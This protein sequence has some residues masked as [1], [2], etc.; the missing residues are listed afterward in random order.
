MDVPVSVAESTEDIRKLI[1]AYRNEVD[2]FLIDTIGYSPNDFE[3]IGKMRKI[4][5]VSGIS[6][7]VYLAFTASTKASDIRDIIQHYELFDFNSVI[8]TKFDETSCVGNVISILQEKNKPVSFITTGQKVPRDIEKASVVRFLIQLT[9]FK[10]DRDR[11]DGKFS[12][13]DTIRPS[14]I[15]E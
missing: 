15:R 11:I 13:S 14:M 8:V 7:D 4:L 12:V 10:I 1:S 5:E 6:T 2:V 3:N 9:D